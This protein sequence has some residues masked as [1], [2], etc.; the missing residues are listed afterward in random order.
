M[1]P[2]GSPAYSCA[3]E[4]RLADARLR[5]WLIANLAA[6]A[7][8]AA[9]VWQFITPPE[10]ATRVRNALVANI[11]S[12]SDFDWTPAT[13]PATFRNETTA[14]P[15]ELVNVVHRIGADPGGGASSLQRALRIASHLG[16][17]GI[18]GGMLQLDTISAYRAIVTS[19]AGYCADYTQVFNALA[20][21]ADVPVRQWGMS[22][23]GFGGNGHAYN[24]IYDAQLRQWVLVDAFNAFYVEDTATGRPVSALEFR[25]RLRDPDVL[26]NVKIVRLGRRFGFRDDADLVEYFRRGS[27]QY[28]LQWGNNS[29]SYDAQPMV[30]IWAPW[31]RVGHQLAGMITGVHP[32]LRVLPSDSNGDLIRRLRTVAVMFWVLTGASALLAISSIWLGVRWLRTAKG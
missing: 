17:G 27:D 30:R 19:G 15:Q 18:R 5:G 25:E 3:P 13:R 6:C 24:E 14:K 23:D 12:P 2:S 11:G 4:R 10:D 26:A 22:F 20:Y 21:V 32:G 16:E 29:L 1:N 28:F 8:L 7:L 31:S 9:S